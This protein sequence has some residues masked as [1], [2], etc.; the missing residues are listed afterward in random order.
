[1][2]FLVGSGRADG[3]DGGPAECCFYH[4]RGIAVD[5]ESHSCV[6]VDRG[7]HAIRKV[8]FCAPI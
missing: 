8:S 5:E 3:V 2:E 1:M 7:N 6:V 4:P